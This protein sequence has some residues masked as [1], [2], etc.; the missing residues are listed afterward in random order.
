[1]L[2]KLTGLL[3]SEMALDKAKGKAKDCLL[4]NTENVRMSVTVH[5]VS[6]QCL[7]YSIQTDTFDA[8]VV[9]PGWTEQQ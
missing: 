3:G 4:V 8:A 6:I 2:F 1:M 7:L 9:P 5:K